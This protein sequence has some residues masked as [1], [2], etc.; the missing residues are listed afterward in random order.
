L[1]GALIHP[2]AGFPVRCSS[3]FTIPGPS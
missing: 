1:R 2:G 3:W